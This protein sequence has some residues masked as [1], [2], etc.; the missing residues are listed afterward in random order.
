MHWQ[1]QRLQGRAALE[2]SDSCWRHVLCAAKGGGL[3]SASLFKRLLS[4][5][6]AIQRHIIR[7]RLQVPGSCVTTPFIKLS[8][9][10]CP[11]QTAAAAVH[12]A[13]V[14]CRR[15]A[16]TQIGALQSMQVGQQ[17]SAS[18]VGNAA[19]VE[20]ERSQ[21]RTSAECSL[22]AVCMYT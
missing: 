8:M 2:W 7:T 12:Q 13:S 20:R 10:T 21:P 1:K 6:A 17:Q 14:L 18:F 9:D 3:L 22:P 19:A 15:H 16:A 11:C 5:G 4:N